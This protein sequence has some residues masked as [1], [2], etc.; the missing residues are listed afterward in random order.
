MTRG[1]TY[2]VLKATEATAWQSV[3]AVC[4]CCLTHGFCHWTLISS[5]YSG[6]EASGSACKKRMVIECCHLSMPSP[7]PAWSAGPVCVQHALYY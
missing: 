3:D 1:L 4:L 5:D 7:R 2:S 6:M